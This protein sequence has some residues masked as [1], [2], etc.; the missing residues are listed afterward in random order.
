MTV[1]AA[2]GVVLAVWTSSSLAANLIR[3]GEALMGKPAVAN[4]VIIVTH[5]DAENRWIGIQGQPGGVGLVDCTP[6]LGDAHTRGNYDQV[7][8]LA[9]GR[10]AFSTELKTFLA[11]CAASLGVRYDWAG[12]AEDTAAALRLN[13]LREALNQVYRWPSG[14]GQMPG[15]MVCSSLAAWQYEHVKWPHPDPGTERQCNPAGWWDW[16][17]RHS[18]TAAG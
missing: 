8:A 15:E 18:W 10:P 7:A 9:A 6:F 1:Q 14:S 3:A 16:S 13:V 12:I 2:P 17:D 4:H 5:R 11:S